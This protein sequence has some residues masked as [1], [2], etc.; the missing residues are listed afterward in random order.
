M[1]R[2]LCTDLSEIKLPQE[3]DKSSIN[4]YS[5]ISPSKIFD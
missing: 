5:I 1:E 4:T 3:N 2:K